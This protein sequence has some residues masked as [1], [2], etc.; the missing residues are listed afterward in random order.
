MVFSRTALSCAEYKRIAWVVHGEAAAAVVH[1]EAGATVVHGEVGAGVVV[2]HAQQS[3]FVHPVAA[4]TGSPGILVQGAGGQVKEEQVN[5]VVVVHG[6]VVGCKQ[7][8]SA[9]GVPWRLYA[10]GRSTHP[11]GH[12][13]VVQVGVVVVH[14]VVVRHTQQCSFV[15]PVDAQTG[16]PGT[17]AQGAGGHVKEAQ[18]KCVVVVQGVVVRHTQQTSFVHP[19]AAQTGS[20]GTL[21]Q[22]AGGHVKEAQVKCVVVVHGVVVGCKQQSSADGAPW[23]LYACGR[24]THPAG[25]W[26]VIQVGGATVVQGAAGATVVQGAA[27]G[28]GPA[29]VQGLEQETGSTTQTKR[30]ARTHIMNARTVPKLDDQRAYLPGGANR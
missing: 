29:V 23:R 17:L 16:S 3:S 19:V 27:G 21:A 6:V 4:H 10:C 8:S 26:K 1:G 5:C 22:G 28:G 7:Q 24:W 12:W 9:D 25:H 15:H 2:R 30:S 20:P 13:K 18:V 11:T 14:G